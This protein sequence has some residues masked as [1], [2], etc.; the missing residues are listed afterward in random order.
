M[1]IDFMAPNGE[2]KVTSMGDPNSTR[3]YSCHLA[4]FQEDGVFCVIVLNLPGCVTSGDT[5]EEAIANASDAISMA[6]SSYAEQGR[7][8]PWESNYDENIPDDA[9][10][11]WI[12]VNG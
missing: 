4:I 8:I 3:R 1:S 12:L 5:R 11:K 6:I 10:L 7:D 2:Y 9:E